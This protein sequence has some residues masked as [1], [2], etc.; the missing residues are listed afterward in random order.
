[1][2]KNLKIIQGFKYKALFTYYNVISDKFVRYF[3]F[4]VAFC[5]KTAL[6]GPLQG[7]GS[8]KKMNPDAALVPLKRATHQGA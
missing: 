5:I 2:N 4:Y 8:W 6:P 7:R 1:M 3:L